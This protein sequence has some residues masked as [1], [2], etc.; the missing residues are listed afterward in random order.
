MMQARFLCKGD[1]FTRHG[2]VFIAMDRPA[3]GVAT[4]TIEC[5]SEDEA[6]TVVLD[7]LERVS[8]V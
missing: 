6:E 8:L 1:T 4:V 5:V 2:D 7:A 3:L